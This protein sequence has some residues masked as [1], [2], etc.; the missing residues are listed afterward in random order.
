MKRVVI[1][2]PYSGETERNIAYARAAV[3][4]S[5]L[6]G[7]S[8]IAWHLLYTQPGILD[9]NDANQRQWG[10]SA[11]LSW[12][13]AADA[14]AVYIDRGITP[15]MQS[16]IAAAEDIHLPVEYRTVAAKGAAAW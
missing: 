5:L 16:G 1:E 9:D 8:P 4:D 13:Q 7:E 2:S 15:N 3:R 14:V 11:G 10:I 12:L 6:R